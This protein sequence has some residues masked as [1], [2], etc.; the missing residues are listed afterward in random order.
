[1]E[2]RAPSVVM[3]TARKGGPHLTA[4]GELDAAGA[5]RLRAQLDDAL[6]A[7]DSG[8]STVSLDLS[9][10]T[11]VSADALAVLVGAYRRLREAGGRLELTEVSPA[12]VRVL[13]ISGL[14]RVLTPAS[15]APPTGAEA[16]GA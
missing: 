7:G 6:V 2:E 1:M 9:R 16:P 15:A 11:H 10:V 14:H 5:I 3:T 12:V 8:P 4:S 13:R